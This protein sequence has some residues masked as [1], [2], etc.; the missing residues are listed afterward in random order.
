[1]TDPYPTI[2]NN[3]ENISMK[4]TGIQFLVLAILVAGA[5]GFAGFA[6]AHDMGTPIASPMSGMHNA[7]DGHTMGGNG[8]AYFT[9]TNNG[10]DTDRLIAVSAPVASVVEVHEIT[11]KDGLKEMRPLENGLEIPAGETVTLAPGGYHIMMIG[12]HE[13][14]NV[15]MTFDLTLTFEHAGEIVIP[16]NVQ[17]AAP[18]DDDNLAITVG[19]L[20]ITGIWSR[21]APALQM[22]GTPV[23]S[24]VSHHSM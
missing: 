14:L 19:D 8:A 2:T 10:T 7:N 5:I 16:V 11:D 24:P 6:T 23:A 13:D 4:R 18:A 3:K 20:V 12:L 1:M 15:D 21:P 9:V 17:R 22:S